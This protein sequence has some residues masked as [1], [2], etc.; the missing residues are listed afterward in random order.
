MIFVGN[1]RGNG[2]NLARHLMS[3]EN[4]HVTVHEVSGFVGDDLAGAFKEAEATARGTRCQKYLY[5]LSLNPPSTENI[6]TEIFLEAISRVEDRLGLAG[7]PRAVVF[8]EKDNRRHCHVVW[9]RIDSQEMKAIPVSFPKLKLMELSKEL[10]LE[11][12]WDMPDGFLQPRFR[13]PKNF[14]LAEWQQAKRIGEDAREL[15]AIFQSCWRQSDDPKSLANS[16]QEHGLMLAKGDRR[17]FVATDINGEVY[18]V[19]R[20]C[21]VKTKEVGARLG[22]PEQLPSIAEAQRQLANRALPGVQRLEQREAAKLNQLTGQQEKLLWKLA[23][24]HAE[25]RKA[26]SVRQ[27]IRTSKE[28]ALRQE[29]FNTGLR[30][31]FDRITGAYTKLK[32]QNELETFEA[33]KR[34]QKERDALIF[35]QMDQ[36]REMARNSQRLLEKSQRATRELRQDLARLSKGPDESPRARDGPSR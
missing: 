24:K 19:A 16:L 4:E 27:D 23:D 18:A 13:D 31:L 1:V 10:Y 6:R 3:S 25:E 35:R 26:L 15:K 17:G 34:D 2:Q 7:Q 22:D 28:L 12:G 29:R 5:S 36:K 30:G 11:H 33:A 20:W 32:R 9:S 21:G 8:H 14:T